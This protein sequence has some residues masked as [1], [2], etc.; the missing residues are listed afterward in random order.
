MEIQE[1][2]AAFMGDYLGRQLAGPVRFEAEIRA[3]A[4]A[5]YD[6]FVEVG[7]GRTLCGLVRRIDRNLRCYNVEDGESL[8]KAVEQLGMR[9]EE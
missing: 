4:A 2:L 6:T 5:G 7:A 9:S 3:L 8:G 1:P